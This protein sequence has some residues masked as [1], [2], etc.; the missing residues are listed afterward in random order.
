MTKKYN[1]EFKKQVVNNFLSATS[2]SNLS[3]EYGIPK[4]TIARWIKK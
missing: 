4:S 1:D 3:K 2:Y